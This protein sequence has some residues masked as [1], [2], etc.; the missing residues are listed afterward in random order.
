MAQN[1]NLHCEIG[2][3]YG[4]CVRCLTP[5]QN[6]KKWTK[7]TS[8]LYQYQ[9]TSSKR[10][11]SVVQ[12]MELPN[13]NECTATPRTCCRKLANRAHD[14]LRKARK[15]KS[16]GYKTNSEKM[17]RWWQT[18]LVLVRNWVDWRTDCSLWRTCIGRPFY[19]A[20]RG[21][22]S[23]WEKLGTQV[24][25]RRR[26]RT[27]ESTTGFRWTE[28]ERK[29]L[30]DE[31]VNGTSERNTPFHPV[32]RS[33]QQ[34]SAP[35]FTFLNIPKRWSRWPSKAE[36]QQWDTCPEPTELRL[37]G[38]FRR[39]K[40][41]RQAHLPHATCSHVR[42][43]HRSHSTDDM[44]TLAQGAQ[45]SRRVVRRKTTVHPR[46]VVR[47]LLHATLSTSSPSL[48]FHLCCVVVVFFS[49]PRPVVHVSYYPLRRSTAGWHFYGIH[50][51]HKSNTLTPK[52]NSQTY[53]Q[54]TISHVMSGTIFSVCSLSAFSALSAALEQCRKGYRKEQKTVASSSTAQSSSAVNGPGILEAPCES[55]S[56]TACAERSAAE[57]SN[58]NDATSSSQVWQSDA[59][60]IASAGRPAAE[61]SGIVNVDSVWPNNFQISVACVP[62]LE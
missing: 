34:R 57:D 17:A 37:T 30:H 35:Y 23:Y 19:I 6:T 24:E 58:Q 20:T 5:S 44:C 42:S 4:S 22:R 56:L 33:R 29:R 36:V 28:R 51:F 54:M 59:K 26:S 49:E 52:T 25:H 40:S 21:E 53:W 14:M 27:N 61:G 3:V 39:S 32:Q 15:H 16:G 47:P 8:T 50:L 9:V 12:D 10:T 31:H 13:G 11:Y 1:C 46:V 55:L 48:F 7:R 62:H 45:G 38:Y 41:C 43:L 18:P 2:I 60:T